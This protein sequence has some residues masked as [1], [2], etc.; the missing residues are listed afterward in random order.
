[1]SALA[2]HHCYMALLRSRFVDYYD[3]TYN[4]MFGCTYAACFVIS[5]P[6]AF[7]L[8]FCALESQ[9]KIVFCNKG[10]VIILPSNCL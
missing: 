10:K 6:Q 3:L 1:M 8:R 5:L 7:K 2:C 9:R 4:K